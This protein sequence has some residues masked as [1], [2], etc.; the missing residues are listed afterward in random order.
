MPIKLT[1]KNLFLEQNVYYCLKRLKVIVKICMNTS[2]EYL[3]KHCYEHCSK[4]CKR[5]LKRRIQGHLFCVWFVYRECK[6]FTYDILFDVYF[7]ASF[8]SKCFSHRGYYGL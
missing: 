1:L 7:A 8:K 6:N 3:V 4:C 2:N 5:F